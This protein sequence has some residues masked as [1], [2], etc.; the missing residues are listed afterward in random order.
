M[1]HFIKTAYG[2]SRTSYGNDTHNPLQ[3]G[4]QGN[5]ASMPFFVAITSILIPLLEQYVECIT[6]YSAIS[7]TVLSLI[8][9]IYVDDSDFLIAARYPNDEPSKIVQRTQQA[10]D[11]WQQSVHQTGG[12]IRPHKCRWALV[13]FKWKNGIASYKRNDEVQGVLKIK[14]TTGVRQTIQRL[15]PDESE[16]GL[17]IHI[18]VDGSQMNQVTNINR[19]TIKWIDGIKSSALTKKEVYVSLMIYVTK[20]VAYSLTAT[21]IDEK[22][23]TKIS[24]PIYK[25]ALP[26]MGI[27]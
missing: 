17:G 15:Q 9:I 24:I 5:G 13:A 27:K 16:E 20:T 1:N 4:G 7:L 2:D 14:D 11:I 12:A 21:S 25:T 19:K 8:V 10:A 3:G 23:M 22:Q 26:R 18:P 6:I